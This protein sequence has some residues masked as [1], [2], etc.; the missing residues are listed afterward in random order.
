MG[1]LNISELFYVVRQLSLGWVYAKV[2]VNHFLYPN[3]A[4]EGER[5]DAE[6]PGDVPAAGLC[7]GLPGSVWQ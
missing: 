4:W 2:C 6:G 1:F 5:R 3:K 7:R